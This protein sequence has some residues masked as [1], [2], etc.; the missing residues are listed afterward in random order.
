ML[1]FDPHLIKDEAVRDRYLRVLRRGETMAATMFDSFGDSRAPVRTLFVEEGTFNAYAMR[2]DA[3]YVLAITRP[4]PLLLLILFEKL[5]GDSRLFPWLDSD[6]AVAV[7]YDVD[8]VAD[9]VDFSRR[10]EWKISLTDD[11]AFV[12]G[13][14][15]EITTAFIQMHEL[16][17]V[18][19]GHI[20]ANHHL[21]SRWSV[22]ELVDGNSPPRRQ[23]E[24]ERAWE[25]DA[26]AIAASLLVR[27]LGELIDQTHLDNPARKTFGYGNQTVEH[28]LAITAVALFAVF[29]YVRGERYK[30]GKRSSHPHPFV[31]SFYVKDMLFTAARREWT[32]DDDVLGQLLDS[33]L[34]EMLVALETI[35]LFQA[36]RI[37]DGY[38]ARAEASMNR[39]IGAR[40]KHRKVCSPW[41]W[42]SWP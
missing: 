18:M 40:A 6:A 11:R 29:A 36:H 38:L 28:V 24:R 37:D 42:I 22:A 2:D 26:D 25:A 41:V 21:T 10:E 15:S 3:G 1:Q 19:G 34:D 4:V 13:I 7:G 30:L 8:F 20:E 16:G 31:R 33:R 9:P 27:Y 35:G 5:L 23:L 14:L 17:H 39:I 12:A 32:V